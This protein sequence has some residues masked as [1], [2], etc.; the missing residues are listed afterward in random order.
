M[1]KET[2]TAEQLRQAKD[3][4]KTL[5]SLTNIKDALKNY[6]VGDIYIIEE[7]WD[8]PKNTSVVETTMGFPK[9]YMVCHISSEGIPYLRQITG[10]GNPT[11]DT[12]LPPEAE[13]INVLR[14]YGHNG[15]LDNWRFTPDPEQMDS[16]LLQ[17]EFDPMEQHREKSKLYNQ[18]NKHNKSIAVQSSW[19]NGWK[20]VAA[21][22]KARV[23][24]DKFWTSP[25]KQY[26][27]QSVAK[28]GKQYVITATD[29]N[30]AT[31][32]FG[33][34]NFHGKRLYKEQPRSFKK[35]STK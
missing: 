29:M 7:W 30:N 5:K 18:I 2:L 35:E 28:V 15:R 8:D 10:K 14:Q 13:A 19:T 11:G 25:E 27:I 24:G 12:F 21:F 31:V 6:K 1:A 22:F 9:K 32:T 34:S 33:F 23:A 17:T 4:D 26:V 3:L 20:E 16:I